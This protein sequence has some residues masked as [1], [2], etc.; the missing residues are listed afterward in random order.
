[1]EIHRI[2][3]LPPKKP[4]GK[5]AKRALETRRA[6]IFHDTGFCSGVCVTRDGTIDGIAGPRLKPET[7]EEPEIVKGFVVLSD[8]VSSVVTKW[9]GKQRHLFFDPEEPDRHAKFAARIHPDNVL[10]CMRLSVTHTSSKCACHQDEYNSFN[11][12]FSA[13]VGMSVIRHV[14]GRYVRIGLNA[15]GRKTID[16][17]QS[18][19]KMYGPIQ[20]LVHEEYEK[21]PQKRTVVSRQLLLGGDR[22]GMDGFRSIRQKCNMDP[23]GYYQPFLHYTLKLINH[24]GLSFPETISVVAAIEVNPNTAYYFAAASEALLTTDASKI[25][26]RHRGYSFGYL[27]VNLMMNLRDLP[28]RSQSMKP[29]GLRFNMYCTPVI[30]SPR[31]WDDRCKLK[32][33][34]C[35]RFHAAFGDIICKKKRA[36]QYK[37]LRS[38]FSST[39]KNCDVLVT[40]HVLAICSCL[41]LLPAWVRREVEIPPSGRVMKYFIDTFDLESS[42]DTVDQIVGS[43]IYT[44]GKQWGIVFT[45]RHLENIL[46]K[47]FRCCTDSGSDHKFCD[48]AFFGQMMITTQGDDLSISF[49][50]RTGLPDTVVEDYLIKRWAFVNDHL[51]VEEIIGKLGM[52]DKGVPTKKES[53]DWS[54]PDLLMYPRSKTTLEFEI[55]DNVSV[56]CS[57]FLGIQLRKVS[58]SLSK[59]PPHWK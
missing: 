3:S 37:K 41:G 47:T 48:L 18:K 43:L 1:L 26:S 21:M 25:P 29:C 7:F 22:Y 9:S 59:L 30:P 51:T 27:L 54:V 56:T 17:S 42:P 4:T 11:P 34:A 6:T 44:L 45:R 28:S 49:D 58:I 14:R 16:E 52:S 40:N 13:V 19:S 8:F 12:A 39:T 33:L 57:Q 10:E 23:M 55:D 53:E 15:Q 24:F 36:T 2:A 5:G 46:C 35:L 32:T 31:D 20:D 38:H 50:E